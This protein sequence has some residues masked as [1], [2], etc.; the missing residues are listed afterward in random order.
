MN[1]IDI[2]VQTQITNLL[3]STDKLLSITDIKKIVALKSTTNALPKINQIINQ[4][5][6]KNKIIQIK[7]KSTD[8]YIGNNN[9][10]K[11]DFKTSFHKIISKDNL[12]W[13]LRNKPFNENNHIL[14][15]Y[16]NLKSYNNIISS[17]FWFI[18]NPKNMNDKLEIE[19]YTGHWD[20]VYFASFMPEHSESIAM[21]SMYAQ[22]WNDGIMII[23]PFNV[24]KN[25]IFNTTEIYPALGKTKKPDINHPITKEYFN[26][27]M[28]RIA[29]SDYDS[30]PLSPTL[31][32]GSA[33]NDQ[34]ENVY[35]YPELTGFIKD[36]AWYYE[37]ELRL[38][39]NL[40]CEQKY[41]GLLIKIPDNL[42]NSLTI[43]FGPR[44]DFSQIKDKTF[45]NSNKK[46][47]Y[48][49]KLSYIPCDN[50]LKKTCY[51]AKDLS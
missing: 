10:K 22:P 9:P 1:T 24:F 30:K 17:K 6:E 49:E 31:Y 26:M 5:K 51:P 28:Y 50:C 8:K 33:K 42:I 36:S 23:I 21:W 16:T 32:C 44:F 12:I 20:D 14:C 41:D 40:T 46:S 38:R 13:Y 4:L 45:V 27:D 18:N 48:H 19:R 29:Y 34:L 35:S 39:I 7:E 3:N 47:I 25:W 15:H 11:E 2:T 43:K 37:K